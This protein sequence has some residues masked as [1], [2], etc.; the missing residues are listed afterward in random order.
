MSLKKFE[1]WL[2]V[3]V[4]WVADLDVG[5]LMVVLALVEVVEDQAMAEGE[6]ALALKRMAETVTGIA[7]KTNLYFYF[8]WLSS[9]GTGNNIVEN[10]DWCSERGDAGG[11]F[12]GKSFHERMFGGGEK[13]ERSR[14][15]PK[16]GGSGWG[17]SRSRSRSPE[18]FDN[19]PPVR[20]FHQAMMER[21]AAA[22][23]MNGPR[24]DE[25]EGRGW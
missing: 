12:Q 9:F 18:R 14:S 3:V 22:P 10:V 8:L 1:K 13:R 21:A 24:A 17:V 7:I 2:H 16:K 15:P 25:E 6:I 4:E 11:G 19:G 5:H 20:S 23:R